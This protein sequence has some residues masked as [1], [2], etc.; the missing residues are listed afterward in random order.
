MEGF[1]MQVGK[2]VLLLSDDAY[3][4][5]DQLKHDNEV[6]QSVPEWRTF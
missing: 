3:Y 6:A 2:T 1:V 5:V 4:E